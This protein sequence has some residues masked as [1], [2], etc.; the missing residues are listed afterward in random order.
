[1]MTGKKKLKTISREVISS[2]IG[3][4]KIHKLTASQVKTNI[5]DLIT[6]VWLCSSFD[7]A[8]ATGIVEKLDDVVFE[9]EKEYDLLNKHK[10][11]KNGD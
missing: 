7:E 2:E 9:I 11:I 3:F 1:M 6:W 8:K 4:P 5:I 10:E